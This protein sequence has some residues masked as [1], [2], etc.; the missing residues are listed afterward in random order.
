[1]AAIRKHG[2]EEPTPI[3]CQ[4]MRPFAPHADPSPSPP[5]P[6]RP[7]HHASPAPRG[8]RIVSALL[9]VRLAPQT[10]PVALSGRDMIGIAATGSGKLG[11]L[12][13]LGGCQGPGRAY[14][15]RS[16]ASAAWKLPVA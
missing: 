14:A 9:F 15:P 4:A 5:Q 2:Y 3:Q 11:W 7:R 16:A 1:M 10:L 13:A 6:T 12:K 8:G